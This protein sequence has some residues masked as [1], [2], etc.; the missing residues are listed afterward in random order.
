MKDT[1][2]TTKTHI[3]FSSFLKQ[4]R[5][6]K[7]GK[8]GERKRKITET[9]PSYIHAPSE[10][11]AKLASS[12]INRIE[13]PDSASSWMRRVK[14]GKTFKPM[15]RQSSLSQKPKKPLSLE[16]KQDICQQVFCMMSQGIH[17]KE[18]GVN[19]IF[20]AV[21]DLL[22]MNG[23]N[24]DRAYSDSLETLHACKPH[25]LVTP[26]DTPEK[27]QERRILLADQIRALRAGVF[28]SASFDKSRK[29]RFN[30]SQNLKIVRSIASGKNPLSI[31]KREALEQKARQKQ[32]Q[33]L[34]EY[35]KI[36]ENAKQ[37][38]AL[39]LAMSALS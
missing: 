16:D 2:H 39:A 17:K 6:E 23:G 9:L 21:R 33:T 24:H 29:A 15:S 19:E 7:I 1:T 13:N 28:L 11:M 27:K 37:G 25:K 12:V 14:D 38:D 5:E 31:L 26:H 30:L 35:L 8:N 10:D 20:R 32:F 22:L 34:R 18:G 4:T 36:G 3:S